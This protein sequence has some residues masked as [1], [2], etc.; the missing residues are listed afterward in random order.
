MDS[1]FVKHIKLEIRKALRKKINEE[2]IPVTWHPIRRTVFGCQ[3]MR[4]NIQDRFLLRVAKVWLSSIQYGGIE[5]FWVKIFC[6][7]LLV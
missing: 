5:T 7:N 3:K 2:L 4:K 1:F 6:I